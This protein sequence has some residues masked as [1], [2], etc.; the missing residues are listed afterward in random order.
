MSPI[1]IPLLR[2]SVAFARRLVQAAQV[3]GQPRYH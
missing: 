2:E 3:F 1:E